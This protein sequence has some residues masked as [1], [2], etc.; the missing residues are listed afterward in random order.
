VGHLCV[1]LA[2]HW[3][4]NAERA[5]AELRR[6]VQLEPA[7]AIS[8]SSTSILL[9]HLAHSG[10]AER[11]LAI[12]QSARPTLPSPDQANGIGTWERL[13]GLAEALYLC[14]FRD[15]AASLSPLVEHA[16]DRGPDWINFD[17]RL[18]RTRAGVAAA[19][20]GRWEAAER[21]FA[22]AQEHAQSMRNPL[23]EADLLRLR[24]RMLLD[25]DG[26][27]DHARAVELLGKAL[28]SYRS[29]G[30]P[31]YAAEMEQLLRATRG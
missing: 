22:V 16:L 6:A 28:T 25:R 9:H 19:A 13:F 17:G 18:V 10:Q 24:A 20:G 12:Y 23:E 31:S 2:A 1:G 7:G 14:G 4:G 21:H 26:P 30:M 11:V 27:G 15:E 5:E 29:F 8:G 3:R